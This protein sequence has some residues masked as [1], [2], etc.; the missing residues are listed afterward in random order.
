MGVSKGIRAKKKKRK[1]RR[2][3]KQ[4][5][6][7]DVLSRYNDNFM[8]EMSPSKSTSL[9]WRTG[10]MDKFPSVTPPYYRMKT[11][12]ALFLMSHD[13]LYGLQNNTHDLQK[14]QWFSLH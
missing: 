5:A 11:S 6:F 3:R 14:Q 12:R 9:I 13:G 10:D 2:K 8:L 7:R 1:R 4:R